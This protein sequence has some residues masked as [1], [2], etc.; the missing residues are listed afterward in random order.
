MKP[1]WTAG[2]GGSPR[3][4]A[5]APFRAVGRSRSRSIGRGRRKCCRLC[6]FAPNCVDTLPSSFV[7]RFTE[8]ICHVASTSGLRELCVRRSFRA[9]GG[10]GIAPDVLPAMEVPPLPSTEHPRAR[11]PAPGSVLFDGQFGAELMPISLGQKTTISTAVVLPSKQAMGQNVRFSV[12]T[13]V[14][15][16]DLWS[17]SSPSMP[18][19]AAE[20]NIP[21]TISLRV[22]TGSAYDGSKTIALHAELDG[23]SAGGGDSRVCGHSFEPKLVV[24]YPARRHRDAAHLT[25]PGNDPLKIGAAGAQARRRSLRRGGGRCS[26]STRTPPHRMSCTSGPIPHQAVNMPTPPN[27]AYAPMITTSG[28]ASCYDHN[29]ESQSVAV[30]LPVQQPEPAVLASRPA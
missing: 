22:P 9:G 15:A 30:S 28:M 14:P 23:P 5:P 19:A 11:S 24:E 8:E 21:V 27:G 2:G 4:S 7:T 13:D 16:N 18:P 29:S 25:I 17:R 3:R 12:K 10:C 1:K 26:S 6:F 20:A